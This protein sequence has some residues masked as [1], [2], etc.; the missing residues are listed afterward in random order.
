MLLFFPPSTLKKSS[1]SPTAIAEAVPRRDS[2][3]GDFRTLLK[4]TAKPAEVEAVARPRAESMPGAQQDFRT[5][6]KKRDSKEGGVVAASTKTAATRFGP[7]P[8][9]TSQFNYGFFPLAG[10]AARPMPW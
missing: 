7:E 9:L 10:R 3:E 2:G 8:F 4:K 1:P 5:L 6:L